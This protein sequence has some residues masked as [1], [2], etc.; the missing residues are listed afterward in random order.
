MIAFWLNRRLYE[1]ARKR[2]S[3]KLQMGDTAGTSFGDIRTTLA[4]P[5]NKDMNRLYKNMTGMLDGAMWKVKPRPNR[6]S[7]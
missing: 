1:G 2:W 6:V 5:A 7:R 3:N 4:L